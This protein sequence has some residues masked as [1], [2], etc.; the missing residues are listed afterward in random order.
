MRALLGGHL[1][2]RGDGLFTGDGMRSWYSGSVDISSAGVTVRRGLSG[3]II[4]GAYLLRTAWRKRRSSSSLDT[5][6]RLA[7][8]WTFSSAVVSSKYTSWFHLAC[9]L[10]ESGGEH[11]GDWGG[12]ISFVVGEFRL[13]DVM[14]TALRSAPMGDTA[15][16]WSDDRRGCEPR[17]KDKDTDPGESRSG[18]EPLRLNSARRGGRPEG[19]GHANGSTVS[20]DSKIAFVDPESDRQSSPGGPHANG[21]E[22]VRARIGESTFSD[23]HPIVGIR[24]AMVVVGSV[25]ETSSAFQVKVDSGKVARDDSLSESELYGGAHCGACCPA[26]L[27]C[28]DPPG[29]GAGT[30]GGHE[31]T[32][33]LEVPLRC[34]AQ[35]P[36]LTGSSGSKTRR[37]ETDEGVTK[38]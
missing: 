16:V 8:A 10:G 34:I 18:H 2:Y 5:F 19:V 17:A 36:A 3:D 37:S 7:T 25:W 31:Q 9:S 20:M 24:L 13:R 6:V 32:G 30:G 11:H 12:S 33:T 27:L 14:D 15:F 22:L 21:M 38:E 26:R 29:P 1:A 35:E 28:D 23:V 4:L